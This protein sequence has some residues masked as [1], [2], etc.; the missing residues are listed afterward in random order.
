MITEN[1]SYQIFKKIIRHEDISYINKRKLFFILEQNL[2][3]WHQKLKEVIEKWDQ[4]LNI[5]FQTMGISDNLA[6]EIKSI[7]EDDAWWENWFS[8]F[9]DDIQK[10]NLIT[11]QEFNRIQKEN[12]ADVQ[13]VIRWRE[14]ITAF[15]IIAW[16]WK[17]G[18]ASAVGLWSQNWQNG[19]WVAL[20]F[21]LWLS[22]VNGFR[23]YQVFS[24]TPKQLSRTLKTAIPFVW[25]ALP[26][27]ELVKQYSLELF[28]LAL[29]YRRAKKKKIDPYTMNA[30][31]YQQL[32]KAVKREKLLGEWLKWWENT[33]EQLFL[34][35]QNIA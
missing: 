35:L 17:F 29:I 33:I 21:A 20:I 28:E 3:D 12:I 9:I 30:E 5:F 24:G 11:V 31:Q 27:I 23:S 26:S 14:E 32:K 16:V 34:S 1:L 8:D 15:G 4:A 2:W 7:I 6:K 19:L 10:N 18:L 25:F 13:L 22:T